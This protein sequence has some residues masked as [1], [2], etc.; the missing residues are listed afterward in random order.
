MFNLAMDVT[1]YP[2]PTNS[3]CWVVGWHHE[4]HYTEGGGGDTILLCVHTYMY[5]LDSTVAKIPS[6]RNGHMDPD[7]ASKVE[8]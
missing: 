4:Q 6:V 2:S 7:F 3:I 1:L 8:Q 5:N